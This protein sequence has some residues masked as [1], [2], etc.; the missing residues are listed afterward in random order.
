MGA[1]PQQPLEVLAVCPSPECRCPA[2]SAARSPQPV[3]TG[4]RPHLLSTRGTK[5][6]PCSPHRRSHFRRAEAATAAGPPSHPRPPSQLRHPRG[7]RGGGQ[8]RPLPHGLHRPSPRKGQEPAAWEGLVRTFP[9]PPCCTPR[10]R[11]APSAPA[12][13]A[14]TPSAPRP[15]CP[16]PPRYLHGGAGRLQGRGDRGTTAA[17]SAATSSLSR[18]R[19]RHPGTPGSLGS[20]CP[21]RSTAPGPGGAEPRKRAVGRGVGVADDLVFSALWKGEGVRLQ[22]ECSPLF[23][24]PEGR[25]RAKQW[26]RRVSHCRHKESVRWRVTFSGRNGAI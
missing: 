11:T 22:H 3:P 16:S 9:A 24:V 18:F 26:C 14:L 15:L 25:L 2:V 4:R 21:S 17:A 7:L 1:V 13:A 23:L 5:Q 6:A 12:P 10:S 19:L 8:G 20:A